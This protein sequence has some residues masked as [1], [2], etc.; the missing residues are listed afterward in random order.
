MK[1]L[2]PS[3]AQGKLLFEHLLVLAFTVFTSSMLVVSNSP[4]PSIAISLALLA[5]GNLPFLVL[6]QRRIRATREHALS[7]QAPPMPANRQPEVA[8]MAEVL[9]PTCLA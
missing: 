3:R 9:R 1:P 2:A 6:L 7:T 4:G 8:A 5:A